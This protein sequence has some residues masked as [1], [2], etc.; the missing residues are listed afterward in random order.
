MAG[1]LL[2]SANPWFATE[3]ATKYRGGKHFAWV[4]EYFDSSQAPT[5]S[6]GTLIAPSSNPRKIYDDLLQD[7]ISQDEHSRIIKGHKQ[8]FIRLAKEWLSKG[9]LTKN[10]FDDI[11]TSV[12]AHSWKIW[13][14]VL[15]VIPTAV[16]D[17]ARITTVPRPSRAGY[18]PEYQITDLMRNEFDILDLSALVRHP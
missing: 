3:V 13:K 6:A 10:Q 17:P 18:G 2:Y 12:R 9:Q 14:P 11:I 4:S 15:Y 7:Y 5:V 16:I 8:T 1:L